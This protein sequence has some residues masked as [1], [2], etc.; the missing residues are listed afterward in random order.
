MNGNTPSRRALITSA[1][2]FALGATA[3]ILTGCS[4]SAEPAVSTT[5]PSAV[6]RGSTLKVY[7]WADYISPAN[8]KAFETT[9]G[10]KVSV[11]AYASSEE[12]VSKLRLTAGTGGYDLVVMDGA[13]LPQLVKAKAILPWDKARLKGLSGLSPT[14]VGKAWDPRN[15]FGIPK[16]GGSTGYVWDSAVVT[17]PPASWNDFY[18]DFADP[19]VRGRTSV[20][21]GAPSFVGSYFWGNGISDQTTKAADYQ[22]AQAYFA[23]RVLPHLKEFN[24]YPRAEIASG[25]TVLAQAFTGDARGAMMDGPKTLRFALGSPR[26]DLYVDHWVL[27]AGTRNPS[28]AHAFVNFLLTPKAA[29]A[30]TQFHGYYTGVVASKDVLPPNLPFRE[31]VFFD[32][33]IPADRFVPS[34]L[35]SARKQSVATFQRLKALA[36]K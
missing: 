12:A 20:I 36:A 9:T 21:D 23:K 6:K 8:I 13:Y 3:G 7:S 17:R 27:P 34:E 25:S 24:S 22:A 26:T 11:D 35:T 31:L 5:Y 1:S 29:A 15:E 16:S 18:A 32:E 19:A 28:A 2:L 4:P 14:F 10:V 33:G 30:E